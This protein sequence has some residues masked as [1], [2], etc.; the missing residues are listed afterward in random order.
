M[1]LLV[2][3]IIALGCVGLKILS[4]ER[5]ALTVAATIALAAGV[6]LYFLA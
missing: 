3:A 4:G 1:V 2:C 5:D 6:L